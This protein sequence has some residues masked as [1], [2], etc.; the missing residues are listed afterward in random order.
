MDPET[1]EALEPPTEAELDMLDL[2]FE[3]QETSS[4]L[5]CQVKFNHLLEKKLSPEHEIVVSLPSGVNN[6]WES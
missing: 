3:V 1:F 5:G 6:H 2:A 4:R